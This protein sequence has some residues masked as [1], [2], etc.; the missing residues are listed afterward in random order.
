M[1]TAYVIEDNDLLITLLEQFIS[2]QH[3]ELELLGISSKGDEAMEKCLKLK[4]DL[5]IVD[6]GLP[7]VNGLEILYLLKMKIPETKII[8]FTGRVTEDVIRIANQGHAD[9]IVSKM[10]GIGELD[11][12][13]DAVVNDKGPYLSPDI[14]DKILK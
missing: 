10:S 9:G 5:V 3:S 14:F 7:E 4:P 1:K 8:I 12:A 6:V 11:K 13:I 2:S